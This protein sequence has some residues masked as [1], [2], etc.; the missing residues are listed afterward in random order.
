MLLDSPTARAQVLR[1]IFPESETMRVDRNHVQGFREHLA[2]M[3]VSA[4]TVEK[5][6][7]NVMLARKRVLCPYESWREADVLEYL[8]EQRKRDIAAETWR[9]YRFALQAFFRDYLDRDWDI[10]DKP[11][12]APE[13]RQ[14]GRCINSEEW[15]AVYRKIRNPIHAAVLGM[16][17]SCGLRISEACRIE[18]THFEES[19]NLRVVGKGEKLRYVPIPPRILEYLRS[20]WRRHRNPRYLFPQSDNTKCVSPDVV[21]ETWRLARIEAGIKQRYGTHSLRHG[22]AT[23]LY[24]ADIPEDVI[25]QLL[26]HAQVSTTRRY[27][28]VTPDQQRRVVE[29]IAG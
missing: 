6:S 28:H 7:Q 23:R 29:V 18:I 10:W 1:A 25:R 13:R 15:R 12:R 5:W 20:L 11:L 21:A 24:D 17:W 3:G 8:K 26:G 27:L 2:D 22:Y 4:R 19:G 9:G 16:C 14:P